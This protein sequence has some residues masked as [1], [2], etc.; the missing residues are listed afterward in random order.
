LQVIGF[1]RRALTMLTQV[2]QNLQSQPDSLT[3]VIE[4]RSLGD[5]LQLI[6]D[7]EKS[8]EVLQQSL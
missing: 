5:T 2:S 7:L 1:Y 3:K 8:R 4:L 6:G